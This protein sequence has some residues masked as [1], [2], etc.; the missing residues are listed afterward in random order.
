VFSEQLQPQGL[1]SPIEQLLDGEGCHLPLPTLH[2]RE[3]LG[4]T[5]HT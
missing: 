5:R 2:R 4:E 3:L 1:A